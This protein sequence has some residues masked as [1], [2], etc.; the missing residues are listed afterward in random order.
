MNY[1]DDVAR[2]IRAAV[3]SGDLP[4]DDTRG[5][6]RMYALLL[7]AKGEAV[8]APDVHNAWVAW[9]SGREPSHESLLPYEA[10]A[11]DVAAQDAP[12]VQAIRLVAKSRGTS[13]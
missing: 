13:A 3:P 1:L 12:Y 6:F 8:T 2:Q 7:L 4:H 10:L 11:A 9:M 5:L